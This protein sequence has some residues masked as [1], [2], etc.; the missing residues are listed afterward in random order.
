MTQR[1]KK[2][3][4]PKHDDAM[5]PVLRRKRSEPW[6]ELA[7]GSALAD[8]TRDDEIAFNQ[9]NRQT[10]KYR[11][12]INAYDFVK[13]NRITGDY[14]EF[15]CHRVRTFRMS[16]TEAKRHFLDEMR[17]YAFDSFQGLPPTTSNPSLD[18]WHRPGVLTTTEDEFLRIIREHGVYVNK[19]RAIKGFYDASLTD[20]LG[21]S[22]Q[23]EGSKIAI[24]CIDCDLYES[25]QPVFAFIEPFLQEGSLLYIDDLWAGYKGSPQKGVAR[26][27]V[28][29]Q[30]QSKFRFAPHMTVGWW[31]KC[32]IA[33]RP[34]PAL[35]EWPGD[36]VL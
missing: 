5:S 4:V 18:L 16:L 29:F 17:F 23:A 24:A 3:P 13:D 8:W 12:Y 32:Y 27:F 22:L 9:M 34:D 31:G 35:G 6:V 11:F 10:E 19:V 26:A 33:Y 7:N 1:T 21:R 25:A 20:E 14:Y 36:A 15:G 28:E 30:R 2:A